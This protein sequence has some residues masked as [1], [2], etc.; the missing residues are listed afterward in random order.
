MMKVRGFPPRSQ[1]PVILH[2]AW[3]H[4]KPAMLEAPT[5]LKNEVNDEDDSY[6]VT[7]YTK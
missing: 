3:G 4:D 5:G 1:C 7:F 6:D 2:L